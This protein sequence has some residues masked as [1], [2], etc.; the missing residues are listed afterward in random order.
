[1]GGRFSY[2]HELDFAIIGNHIKQRRKAMGITQEQLANYL[3]VNPSHISNIESGRAHP[4]LTALV[5]IANYLKCSIDLFIWSEYDSDI[6]ENL[7]KKHYKTKLDNRLEKKLK[8]CDDSTKERI[9]KI[10]D[11]LQ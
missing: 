8:S 10:I 11:I 4:S 5:C 7:D 6:E 2:M 3:D 9:I 1:M